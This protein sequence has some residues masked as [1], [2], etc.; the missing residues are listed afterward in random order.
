MRPRPIGDYELAK[1]LEP[2]IF[3]L[4]DALSA[5]IQK[6]RKKPEVNGE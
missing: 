6:C 2:Y 1:L 3:Q 4:W 5:K